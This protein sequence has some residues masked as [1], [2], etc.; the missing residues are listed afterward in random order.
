MIHVAGGVIYH[1]EKGI[2]LVNQNHDSWS[3]PKGHVENEESPKEAAYREIWEETGLNE[4]H[5]TFIAPLGFY[6]RMRI[7]KHP[8]DSDELR[9][10]TMYLFTTQD[11][12]LTP[13]SSEITGALWTP[14]EEVVDRLTHPRDKAFFTSIKPHIETYVSRARTT[15]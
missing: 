7:K 1:Q 9:T 6:E 8:T 11:E 4:S 3:F 10:I 12:N 5:L 13:H 15:E 2:A 14:V